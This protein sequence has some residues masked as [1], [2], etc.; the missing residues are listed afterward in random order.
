MLAGNCDGSGDG[1]GEGAPETDG[2]IEDGVNAPEEG[3]AKSGQAVHE[4]FVK[5]MGFVNAFGAD[6][7]RMR[8]IRAVH[9]ILNVPDSLRSRRNEPMS[10]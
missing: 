5:R 7:A 6:N 10:S 4:E 8:K 3:T 1:E 2:G 9:F